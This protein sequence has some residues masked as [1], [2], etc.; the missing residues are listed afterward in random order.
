[1]SPL[2]SGTQ[3]RPGPHSRIGE[4]E[5]DLV[6]AARTNAVER[7]RLVEEYTPRIGNVARAYRHSPGVDPGE[8]VQEGVVGLLRALERFDPELGT[9][10]WPYAAW[11][12]RQAIQRLISERCSPIVLSD[13]ALRQLAR[14]RRARQV[15]V[16]AHA[17]EPTL[18][19]LAEATEM[20]RAHMQSL[21]AAMRR[22]RGLDAR[23]GPDDEGGWTP[24]E[25]LADPQAEDPYERVPEAVAAEQ[26]PGLLAA[27]SSRELLILRGRFGLDGPER[28]LRELGNE[29]DLSAE[30]VRQIEQEALNKLRSAA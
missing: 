6:L 9:P 2:T 29:L 1:M 3:S 24:G 28:T 8:L 18:G 7:T 11:W 12:V 13:R 15:W 30:R 20:T 25:R 22:P 21:L 14:V 4:C 16:Q 27:L 26:L 19:E 10:F 17:R 5:H 23:T